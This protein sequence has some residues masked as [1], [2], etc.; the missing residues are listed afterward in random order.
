VGI[1]VYKTQDS[2]ESAMFLYQLAKKEQTKSKTNINLRFKKAPVKNSY[3]LEYI[4]S[5]IPGIN[6]SRAKNL[7]TTMKTLQ[8]IF[9]SD[10]GELM[11]I[12]GIGRKIAQEIYKLS[13]YT[14][15]EEEI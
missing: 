13:R 11:E 5:G 10:I 3:L 15:D 12:D 1:T 9:N 7:L 8:T 4:I 14:Y 6:S 2:R